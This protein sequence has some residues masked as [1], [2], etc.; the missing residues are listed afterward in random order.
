MDVNYLSRQLQNFHYRLL[1]KR[2]KPF[3]GTPPTQGEVNPHPENIKFPCTVLLYNISTYLYCY[4]TGSHS[5]LLQF[6]VI[7]ISC[8]YV[9]LVYMENSCHQDN[10]SFSTQQSSDKRIWMY[11]GCVAPSLSK[12]WDL[13]YVLLG[14]HCKQDFAYRQYISRIFIW[15]GYNAWHGMVLYT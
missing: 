10:F 3:W 8:F 1:L 6:F 13:S 11:Q 12:R 2:W 5:G 9:M 15:V 7:C 14:M 4:Y